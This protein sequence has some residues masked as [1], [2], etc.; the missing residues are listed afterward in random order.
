MPARA[1]AGGGKH[2]ALPS[3]MRRYIDMAGSSGTENRGRCQALF[4]G[5]SGM[6]G[7]SHFP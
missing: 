6:P 2:Q 5:C 1:P 7:L 3:F 4:H